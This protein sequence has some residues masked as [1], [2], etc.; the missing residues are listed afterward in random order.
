VSATTHD[1]LT[2]WRAWL[3]AC[4][5][6]PQTIRL[7]CYQLARFA[8]HHPT[9][10]AVTTDELTGWLART[11]WATDTRR[12]QLAALRSFYGW[13]HA[14]GRLSTDPSRLLPR[15]RPAQHVPRPASERAVRVAMIGSD[16][17]VRLMLTLAVRQGLRRGEIALVHSDDITE[18]LDG[19]SLTVHG[20]GRK[21]RTIPLADDVADQLR[22]LPAGWAF[23]GLSDGHLSAGHVGVLMA[24]A[25]P[26]GLTAHTLR[27][28]FATKA[29]GATRDLL[30]VQEL[31][32]H[33][34]PETTRGYILLPGDSLRAAV[35]GAA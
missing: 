3:V 31:L 7:R 23:P 35:T 25:L 5:L 32:G 20:K 1:D 30:A 9:L 12:S 24:R 10:R 29:Y 4:D 13:A 34:R 15:I 6:S 26:D 33:A 22:G 11:G 19:W 2:A 28:R 14:S 17:R 18:D 16:A 8:E 21:D 27:H